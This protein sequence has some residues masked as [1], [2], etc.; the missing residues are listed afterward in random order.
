MF[1]LGP[2]NTGIDGS[3]VWIKYS[4]ELK[5]PHTYLNNAASDQDLY[6]LTQCFLDT[7]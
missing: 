3:E 1:G 6:C 7:L 5:C 2:I 4:K